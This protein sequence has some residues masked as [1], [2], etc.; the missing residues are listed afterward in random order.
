MSARSRRARSPRSSAGDRHVI[1]G[2]GGTRVPLITRE[3][4]ETRVRVEIATT[5]NGVATTA[6]TS[7]P[8]LDHML[9]TLG[10]YAGLGL[11]VE[12]HGDLRHHIVEDVAICVGA[13]V[14]QV[15]PSHAVR[16]GDRSIPMDD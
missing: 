4:N 9:V 10:R 3:T 5:S 13:A 11:H 7:V 6:D 2:S 8:F 12:A 14:A 1:N 15:S 16:Y